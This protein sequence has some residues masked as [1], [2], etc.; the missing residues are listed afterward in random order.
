MI[1]IFTGWGY[2]KGQGVL[3]PAKPSLGNKVICRYPGFTFQTFSLSLWNYGD[4]PIAYH[5]DWCRFEPRTVHMWDKPSSACGCV[6]CFFRG[7]PVSPHLPIGS[8]R[9]DMSEIILKGP[10]N[11]MKKK[12]HWKKSFFPKKYIILLPCC[13]VYWS[14]CSRSLLPPA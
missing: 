8:S 13:S 7:T 5:C 4:R 14:N 2:L 6:R 10:L 11:W 9:S 12:M 3:I 1:D